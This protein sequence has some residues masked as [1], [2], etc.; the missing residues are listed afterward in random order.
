MKEKKKYTDYCSDQVKHGRLV[1]LLFVSRY[2][3]KKKNVCYKS[4]RRPNSLLKWDRINTQPIFFWSK[5]VP[6][7]TIIY[8]AVTL[9][10]FTLP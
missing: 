2:V 5:N 4:K 9:H 1:L 8:T 6:E 7:V 10:Y 3:W